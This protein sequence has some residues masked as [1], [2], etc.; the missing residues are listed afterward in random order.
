MKQKLQASAPTGETSPNDSPAP[1]DSPAPQDVSAPNDTPASDDVPRIVGIGASAGGMAALQAFFGGL[2]DATGLAFA[3]VVH[4]SPEHESTLAQRLQ[5]HTPMPCVQVTG[6]VLLE[7]DHV[8]VIPPGLK[9]AVV[10]GHLDVTP[11]DEPFAR[12]AAIDL[13]LRSLADIHPDGLAVILSGAGADG[14]SGLKRLKERGGII[15]VQDPEEAEFDGMPRS[16]IAT[17]LVDVVLP[18]RELA[19]RLVSLVRAGR[20]SVGR[21]SDTLAAAESEELGRILALL[22]EQTGYDFADYK[23]STVL[24]RLSRRLQVHSLGALGPYEALLRERPDECHA[25]FKDLLISVTNFFRDPETCEALERDVVPGLFE[26]KST[27]DT[28]RVWSAG[29]ATGEEAYSLAILLCEQADR[30]DAPPS[31]QVFATD[32]S[33]DA[34]DVARAGLYADTIVADVSPERLKRFFVRDGA[35]YKIRPE[36]RARIVFARHSLIKDPSFSRLDLVVCRN[37]LIY[38]ARS[39]QPR[40]FGMLHHALRPG[41]FL[42]L[43]TAESPEGATDLFSKVAKQNRIYRR[44]DVE[45]PL[46]LPPGALAPLAVPA[47]VG[48]WALRPGNRAQRAEASVPLEAPSVL[49]TM[50]NGFVPPGVIVDERQEI[51]YLSDGAGRYLLHA[52]G[53]PT[54][55]LV[56]LARKELRADLRIGLHEAFVHGRP[57]GSRPIRSTLDGESRHIHLIVR[58]GTEAAGTRALALVIFSEVEASVPDE[59]V[60]GSASSALRGM[61]EENE[62]IKERLQATIEEHEAS[63][64]DLIA[65]NEEMQSINEELKSTLEDLEANREELQSVNEE[66]HT[67]NAELSASVG[68]LST[69]NSNLENLMAATDIGTLF[70]DRDLCVKSYTPPILDLFNVIP[71]D[72]GR[73]LVHL[74]HRLR[75]DALLADAEAVLATLTPVEREVQSSDERWYLVRVRAFRTLKDRAGGVV[76]SFVDVS[77]RRA[78]EEAL[79][80]S[81]ERLRRE[82]E[83]SKTGLW[84]WNVAENVMTWTPHVHDL[85]GV[86]E[87]AFAGT[88]EALVA[89]VHPEDR[90]A[91][92]QQIEVALQN[93]AAYMCEFRVVS[94]GPGE[95]WVGCQGEVFRTGAGAQQR[96]TGIVHDITA[97]KAA[98]QRMRQSYVA[99]EQRVADRTSELEVANRTLRYRNQQLQDFAHVASHDLQEPLR[100]IQS[101]AG[102]LA[103]S[104]GTTLDEEGHHF[105]SRMQAGAERMSTLIRDL[106]AF[107]QVTTQSTPFKMVDLNATLAGVLSDLEVRLQETGGRVEARALPCIEA[108][109]VQMHQVLLNLVGNA[110]KFHRPGVAPVVRVSGTQTRGTVDLVVDDNGIGFEEK[111]AERIFAPFQRLHAKHQFDGTGMGLS[112]VRKI[113]ERHGGSVTATSTPGAG[114]RFVVSWPRTRPQ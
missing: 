90:E 80:V 82:T 36:L 22:R 23:Q 5:P 89:C 41:G 32:L 4:L 85:L 72:R 71:S 33:D 81:E 18:A 12:R 87:K 96:M 52:T 27:A 9:L 1:D 69:T 40:V 57:W 99:L 67:V 35:F 30:M 20:P 53:R 10:N 37:L 24:R 61:E 111:Y 60:P 13:F 93:E 59:G 51:V 114:S 58:P 45:A 62:R 83:A 66:L 63:A 112:I 8:Y 102:M 77:E 107:S 108:D 64:E 28:V 48:R 98:A 100:K 106:L 84:D 43:G 79:R 109:P 73:P 97:Q 46:A 92:T 75:Y 104:H 101:F 76:L 88:F 42:F 74:T 56:R 17:G 19:A 26:G 34:L 103:T 15:L 16:A 14:A 49:A 55:S 38:I 54:N 39:L 31:F 68:E 110:L 65:S 7:P 21:E 86:D 91:F 44:K 94:A 78:A 29:C 113:A 25:L 3:V 95:Q 6:R 105:I 47:L 11:F 50:L 2:P 70:L